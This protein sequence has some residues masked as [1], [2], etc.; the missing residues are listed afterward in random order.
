[1]RHPTIHGRTESCDRRIGLIRQY[2]PKK[3]ML[4]DYTDDDIVQIQE[5]LNHR[6]RQ[7]L[8]YRTP[9]EVFIERKSRVKKKRGLHLTV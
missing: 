2:I 9:H 4:S 8:G 6:P 7:T 1:M 3:A 5:A